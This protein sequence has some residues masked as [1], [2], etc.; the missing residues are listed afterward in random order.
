MY[1]GTETNT[2]VCLNSII[3]LMEKCVL[4]NQMIIDH[5]T[6][7]GIHNSTARSVSVRSHTD[8]TKEYTV[9]TYPDGRETCTC[10]HYKYRKTICKHMSRTSTT[11]RVSSHTC[12]GKE[13]TVTTYRDG[14]QT[15]TCP[16]YQYRKTKCKHM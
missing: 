15:C 14:R 16:H 3:H 6:Q 13:Y 12:P 7:S 10:P 9:T 8:P 4:Q 11:K 1:T 5:I 2:A